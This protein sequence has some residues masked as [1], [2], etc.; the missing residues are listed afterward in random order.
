MER[1][2]EGTG[3]ESSE[4]RSTGEAVVL[5]RPGAGGAEGVTLSADCAIEEV[6]R[7][8]VRAGGH[9]SR[10]IFYEV[11]ASRASNASSVPWSRAASTEWV[12]GETA[13]AA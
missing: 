13:R 12:T 7:S 5:E 4:T 2:T 9:A 8:V 11:G 1:S 6:V 3:G 10:N